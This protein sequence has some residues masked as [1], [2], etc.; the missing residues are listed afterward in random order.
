[1]GKSTGKRAA[2]LSASRLFPMQRVIFIAVA[3]QLIARISGTT[4]GKLNACSAFLKSF[5]GWYE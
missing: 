5:G 2:R 1:M 4:I 3:I